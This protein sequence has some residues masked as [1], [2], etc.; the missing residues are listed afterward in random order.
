[1][2]FIKATLLLVLALVPIWSTAQQTVFESGKEGYSCYRIPAILKVNKT[3]VAFAEGRRNGCSDFGDVD[4]VM[5]TSNDEGKTWSELKLLVNNETIQ[6]GNPAPV[7]DASD[8]RYPNGRLFL[9]YNTGTASE[10]DIVYGAGVRETWFITSEDLGV[11]WS[12]PQNI[13]LQVHKP[14]EPD[15]NPDYNFK[16]DWRHHAL[17]PGHAIQLENGRLFIPINISIGEPQNGKI[18]YRAGAFYSDDHGKSFKLAK[19]LKS[20]GSNESTGVQLSNGEVI[21]NAR[22]QTEKTGKR[23]TARSTDN[24]QSW[25]TEE[26]DTYLTDPV[27]Q[28]S[29]HIIRRKKKDLVLLSQVF[30]PHKRE[31]LSL[32]FS[33]DGA[34][35]WEKTI[36]IDKGSSAYSDLV[37]LSKN[38]VGVLYEKDDYRRIVFKEIGL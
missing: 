37:V 28:G 12:Q 4:I 19:I 7:F 3:L 17:T 9:F 14:H 33:T 13:T 32:H 20:K 2:S 5:K 8:P 6:A 31:N 18:P 35:T 38:K 16:E 21:L 36:T 27:C 24:G 1:M 11:S 22:D 26:V 29:L 23:Y 15:Y 10:H 25:D 34:R 30:H